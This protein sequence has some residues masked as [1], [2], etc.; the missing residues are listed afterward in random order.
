MTYI[1]LELFPEPFIVTNMDGEIWKTDLA[2]AK[3]VAEN[4]QQGMVVPLCPQL[5]SDLGKIFLSTKEWNT[6]V[7]LDKYFR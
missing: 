5:I 4:C 6:S 7:I 2:T 1:I 3:E